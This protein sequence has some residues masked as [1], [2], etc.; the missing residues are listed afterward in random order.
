MRIIRESSGRARRGP[1]QRRLSSSRGAPWHGEIDVEES[2]EYLTQIKYI[3]IVIKK[4]YMT[5]M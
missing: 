2:V 4:E 3:V 5:T 1:S